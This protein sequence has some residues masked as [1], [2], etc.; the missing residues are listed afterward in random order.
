MAK[1]LKEAAQ[2][3]LNLAPEILAMQ[4]WQSL[5]ASGG[6]RRWEREA[7][8]EATR[9]ALKT[10]RAMWLGVLE[11]WER[12]WFAR[13][14]A[15]K[16]PMRAINGIVYVTGEIKTLRRALGIKPDKETIRK[17]TRDRVRAYRERRFA[18]VEKANAEL[19][20]EPRG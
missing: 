7:V 6:V 2:V 13:F 9:Q 5:I 17:Q 14:T 20:R 10:T 8:S 16:A 12:E 18:A 4:D 15:K 3:I 1:R 11:R 19:C